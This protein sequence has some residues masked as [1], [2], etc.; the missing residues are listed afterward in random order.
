MGGR[1]EGE[2]ERR[3]EYRERTGLGRG[4]N[5]WEDKRE[6]NWSRDRRSEHKVRKERRKT[7]LGTGVNIREK[8]RRA[9][10]GN[11]STCI[12]KGYMYMY[13]V[14]CRQTYVCTCT[15]RS[16]DLHWSS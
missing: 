1:W 7:G 3:S 13:L 5:T 16:T 8:K 6:E 2:R 11:G 12:F 10:V 9:T 15:N 4:V 14:P